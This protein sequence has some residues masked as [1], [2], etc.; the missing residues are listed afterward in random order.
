MALLSSV[1]QMRRPLASHQI[2]SPVHIISLLPSM[3]GSS[4]GAQ[5]PISWRRATNLCAL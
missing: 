1:F 4:A 3:P 5:A 2:T